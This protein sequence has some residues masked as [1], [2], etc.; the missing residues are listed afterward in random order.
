LDLIGKVGMYEGNDE[1]PVRFASYLVRLRANARSIPAYLAYLLNTN[2]I[3]G[4]ARANAFVA[5]GQCNLNST[6]YGEIK[7][8]IPPRDRVSQLT[9][10]LD[11]EFGKLDALIRGRTS[12]YCPPR[13]SLRPH[14]R[15]RHR[16]NRRSRLGSRQGRSR[17]SLRKEINFEN[18]ICGYVAAHDWHQEAGSASF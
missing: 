11:A 10:F 7:V 5:I 9:K 17:M 4:V 18:E 14:I 3:L 6:R 8:A 16:Q 13:A 1:F 15:R 12:Y 2:G